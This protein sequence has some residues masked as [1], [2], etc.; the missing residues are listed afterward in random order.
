M[1]SQR[2]NILYTSGEETRSAIASS[3]N[4]ITASRQEPEDVAETVTP[5]LTIHAPVAR[6]ALHVRQLNNARAMAGW[7]EGLPT[8]RESSAADLETSRE[9]EEPSWR[10]ASCWTPPPSPAIS[11]PSPCPL[12]LAAILES[13]SPEPGSRWRF[14]QLRDIAWRLTDL[15]DT[16]RWQV[17]EDCRGRDDFRTFDKATRRTDDEYW[18]NYL[19]SPRQRVWIERVRGMVADMELVKQDIEEDNDDILYRIVITNMEGP[20]HDPLSARCS[21]IL[22][23]LEYF[24]YKDHTQL[25]LRVQYQ[26]EEALADRIFDLILSP[27]MT[28]DVEEAAREAETCLQHSDRLKR[29]LRSVSEQ[30][31]AMKRWLRSLDPPRAGRAHHELNMRGHWV[32]GMP[33]QVADWL[34]GVRNMRDPYAPSY[35]NERWNCMVWMEDALA[36]MYA[37]YR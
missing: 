20:I 26:E 22:D 34:G 9:E 6:T 31:E 33:P 28:D 37:A 29:E 13:S 8:S 11:T 1:S 21:Y 2:S 10:S 4:S 14:G 19:T 18:W 24:H 3:A 16:L 7:L 5:P 15:P 23:S 27:Q 25:P 32:G 36:E 17:L 35:G 12:E 30:L